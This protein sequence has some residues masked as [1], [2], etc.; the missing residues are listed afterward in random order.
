MERSENI[1]S[2]AKALAAAQGQIEGAKKDSSN[3]HFKSRYA[4]LASC[5]DACRE[6]LSKNGLAVVQAPGQSI[7]G[8]VEMTTMLTHESGEWISERLTIPLAKVD[9]QGYGSA[10]TY[11]RRYALTAMVG[12]A[13]EDDDGNAAARPSGADNNRQRAN[14]ATVDDTQ[15]SVLQT[16]AS[17]VGADLQRFCA[18][19]KVPSLKEIPASRFREALDALNAKAKTKPAKEMEPAE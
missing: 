3:P 1:A 15:L 9:A 13:P 14:G 5:W 17:S 12:I 6:A 8:V 19:F 16:T 18:Y 11:A 10:I 2:L 7:E 4:D